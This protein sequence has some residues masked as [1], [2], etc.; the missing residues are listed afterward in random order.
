[1]YYTYIF[2]YKNTVRDSEH[3]KAEAAQAGD[4]ILA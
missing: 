1:V 2:I 3:C 4:H